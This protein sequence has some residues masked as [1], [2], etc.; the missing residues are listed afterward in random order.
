MA[1][2]PRRRSASASGL[3]GGLLTPPVLLL[4]AGVV[5]ALAI[6]VGGAPARVLNGVG[7]L[8]WIGAAGWMLVALRRQPNRLAI[9]LTALAGALVMA[10]LVRP[11][12][13]LEAIVGFLVAGVAVALV[14]NERSGI[15]AMLAPA[16]YFPLH[17]VVAGGRV[18]LSGGV[19]EVR[20]DPP[21]TEAFVPLSMIAAAAVA[22]VLVGWWLKRRRESGER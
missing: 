14:A 15:W 11:G 6:L 9:G 13:Y 12:T 20:T 21:P 10:V 19:R 5:I 4:L 7:G 1:T 18:A 8:M 2:I 17:I 16:L 3:L 22:G